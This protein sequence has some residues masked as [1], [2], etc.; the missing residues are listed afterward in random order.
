GIFNND[1]IVNLGSTIVAN[2]T[3]GFSNDD[4]RNQLGTINA[5]DSLIRSDAS[6]INGTNVNTL[7]NVDPL[8][9]PV[10]LQDNG[11]PTQTLALQTTSPAIDQGSNPLTLNVDQR[12]ADRTVGGGT[13]IGAFEVVNF[14]AI[15]VDTLEDTIDGD[16]TA[17]DRSLREA[18][19]FIAAGGTITFDAS[20]LNQTITLSGSELDIAK[21]LTIDG[22]TNNITLDGAGLSRVFNIDDGDASTSVAVN[23]SDLT[24]T[25]GAIAGTFD[26]GGGIYNYESL[27]LSNSTIS[28]NSA[29]F[30]AGIGN[31]GT[32]AI[33]N[34][35][36]TGNFGSHG[37]GLYSNQSA[38]VT[39]ST[40]SGNSASARGGAI[41]NRYGTI[42]VIN[43]T[44]SGNTAVNGGGIYNT[45][46]FSTAIVSNSTIYGNTATL[47]GGVFND[48]YASITIRYSTVCNNSVSSTGGGIFNRNDGPVTLISTIVGNNYAST[49][50]SS[51]V[52][53]FGTINA[54]NSL[55]ES[56]SGNVNGTNTG[57]I[58]DVDPQLD[59]AGLQNNGGPTLTIALQ[60]T[61]PALDA[62][63]NPNGLTADQRGANRTAAVGTDIGAYEID[64]STI[65][66]DTLEDTVDG[67]FSAGDRSL[68]EALAFIT[69]GGTIT[70]DASLLNQTITL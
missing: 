38:S 47:G 63:S 60:D 18:L 6:E 35:S 12:G 59:P 40:L 69:D 58:F 7:T 14:S 13:D 48:S 10:G 45:D 37:G 57:N 21:A 4:L 29:N 15:V 49:G 31:L 65:V 30:G 11:G 51:L 44:I 70:F 16:F 56:D 36:I 61:S 34:S 62:G 26:K 33:A 17:G 46:Y 28:G 41:Y 64:F 3:A 25:G 9:E 27:I 39:N 24:I 19:G 22:S 20:L 55:I 53:Q 32:I 8:F 66:V 52:N 5:S 67:D 1:G 23:L 54:T 2:N 68:R 43:S 42:D 50:Y